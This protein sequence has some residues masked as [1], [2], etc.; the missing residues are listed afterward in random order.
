MSFK[1]RFKGRTSLI[2]KG[3]IES[4]VVS[5]N[6]PV[7]KQYTYEQIIKPLRMNLNDVRKG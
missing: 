4:I 3:G 7:P 6:N 5:P 1:D 2:S